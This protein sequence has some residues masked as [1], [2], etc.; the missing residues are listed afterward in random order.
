[1]ATNTEKQQATDRIERRFEL[2]APRARVWR[3]ITD[4]KEFGTWFEITLDGA[5]A[6]RTTVRGRIRS[7]GYEHMTLEFQVQQMEPESYFSYRWHP[8][9]S[10]PKVDYSAEPTTL[11]EFRL[12]EIA[13]GT[14]VTIVE[15]GF[16]QIPLARRAEAFR[17][18]DEGWTGQSKNLARH[19]A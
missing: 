16:D 2:R 15:S 1:M 8:Y 11:V 14:V 4:P 19:V 18:H 6:P 12:D 3:A 9:P 7:P 13:G 5:F 10:D 17:M